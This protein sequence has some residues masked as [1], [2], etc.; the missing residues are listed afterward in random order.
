MVEQT[1]APT[2]QKREISSVWRPPQSWPGMAC[3]KVRETR[4]LVTRHGGSWFQTLGGEW[5]RRGQRWVRILSWGRRDSLWQT[6]ALFSYGGKESW[7]RVNAWTWRRV[8][9]HCPDVFIHTTTAEKGSFYSVRN[10]TW[11]LN[12]WCS[13]FWCAA[14]FH[15]HISQ[16]VCVFFLW[17]NCNSSSPFTGE[18]SQ[19]QTVPG[20]R[21]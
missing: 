20:T 9:L 19:S 17:Q 2:M 6:Q 4:N 12:T 8:K 13:S 16:Q 5:C 15:V 7:G 14:G 10:L 3:R 1:G 18:R 21:W 11:C